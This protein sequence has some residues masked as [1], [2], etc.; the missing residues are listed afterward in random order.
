MQ[1][2]DG[3]GVGDVAGGHNRIGRVGL[4]DAQIHRLRAGEA[5]R[6][7]AAGIAR[8]VAGPGHQHI[9]VSVHGDAGRALVACG[10]GIGQG[11]D[12]CC[13]ARS[14]EALEV[15]AGA[16]GRILGIAL[17]G[18]HGVA[19]HIGGDAG[20]SLGVGGGGVDQ[21]IGGIKRCIAGAEAA[22]IDAGA[23]SVGAGPAG[24]QLAVGAQG[25]AGG[26]LVA[27]GDAVQ[28]EFAAH[29][30]A[31]RHI[32]L[33]VDTVE[34]AVLGTALPGHH[35][36]TIEVG[37]H[38]GRAL[39]VGG[40]GIH[41]E[42]GTLHHTGG[43]IAL[44][45]DAVAGPVLRAAFPGHHKAAI[46]TH[47][48]AGRALD[49]SGEG[50]H[51]ELAALQGTGSAVTL[52]VDA[53]QIAVLG[54]AFPHHHEAAARCHGHGGAALVAC[55]GGVHQHIGRALERAKAVDLAHI[56]IGIAGTGSTLPDHY[57]VAV[58]IAR[59]GRC[60][61]VECEAGAVEQQLATERC[62]HRASVAERQCCQGECGCDD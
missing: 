6:K 10:G 53:E 15:D 57:G 47:G 3:Y 21:H 30:R 35:E 56:D 38:T 5:A 13:Q 8:T 52:A 37:G 11:F 41:P 46:A 28:T 60:H 7:H 48:H 24:Q 14:T 49:F 62:A 45:V 39:A 55:G 23:G 50:V 43:V 19:V 20:R 42:L 61:L 58:G 36:I 9:A 12:A 33:G 17:P 22:H 44:G 2:G 16:A 51:L 34:V 31:I 27:G 29:G 1:I 40:G 59:G 26:G 54:I 4:G 18:H 32:A 25:D